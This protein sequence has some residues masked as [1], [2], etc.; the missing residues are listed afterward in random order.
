M[1]SFP[2][3]RSALRGGRLESSGRDCVD[4]EV[5]VSVGRH[6]S[7]RLSRSAAARDP[8]GRVQ[9][10]SSS[11]RDRNV[12]GYLNGP[13]DAPCCGSIMPELL[14]CKAVIARNVTGRASMRIDR[15]FVGVFRSAGVRKTRFGPEV[16][17]VASAGDANSL[18]DRHCLRGAAA[19]QPCPR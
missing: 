7:V 12:G 14:E 6:P 5:P 11:A 4:C 8:C 18:L 1:G 2:V 3:R 9:S 17:Y 16:L 15:L 10:S 19:W 13:Q